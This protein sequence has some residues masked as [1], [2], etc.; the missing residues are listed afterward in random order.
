M[1]SS[2]CHLFSLFYQ[3]ALFSDQTILEGYQHRLFLKRGWELWAMGA[4]SYGQLGDGTNTDKIFLL[5]IESIGII[6]VS[7][8][9]DIAVYSLFIK[10]DGSFVGNG[11]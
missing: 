3:S 1:F 2:T 4:N 11:I 5:E 8:L 9:A 7:A 6:A 10:A